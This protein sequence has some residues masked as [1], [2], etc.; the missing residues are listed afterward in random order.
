MRDLRFAFTL[1]FYGGDLGGSFDPAVTLGWVE[2]HEEG[3]VTIP[4]TRSGP[5]QARLAME[6]YEAVIK[7]IRD[8]W[9]YVSPY[10]IFIYA[11]YG[12]D[13]SV[14]WGPVISTEVDTETGNFVLNAVDYSLRMQSHFFRRGDSP[15]GS[16]NK[17]KIIVGPS[18]IDDCLAAARNTVGQDADGTPPLGIEL[19]A[20]TVVD[21]TKTFSVDRG[22]EVWQTAL[23]IQ[24]A[25]LLEFWLQP[26]RFDPTSPFYYD[27]I[28]EPY[29]RGTQNN[30]LKLWAG[31]GKNN[32]EAVWKPGGKLVTHVHVV[33]KSG[34]RRTRA[35][36][37]AR[38]RYGVW[39]EW[40]PFDHVVTRDA[41][42][43]AILDAIGDT[44][45]DLYSS[46]L[47]NLSLKLLP[48]APKYLDQ[49]FLG[50][51]GLVYFDEGYTAQETLAMEIYINE[52]RL[53]KNNQSSLTTEEVD[54]L[55]W[56][57]TAYETVDEGG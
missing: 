33:D 55:P 10:E 9:G 31:I 54:V 50:D 25:R 36:T 45:L 42:G 48:E 16:S 26:R 35:N 46:P 4:R 1:P 24:G 44:I 53:R 52:V 37:A 57:D 32:A 30:K 39:V 13:D 41:N 6:S 19:N 12:T 56:N 8:Y 20:T 23:D 11:D 51:R 17:G 34:Y 28:M 38:S 21:S 14:F 43:R 29:P 27:L 22:Q 18:G 7:K 47:N 15:L 49:F 2:N 5:L 3:L 40:E